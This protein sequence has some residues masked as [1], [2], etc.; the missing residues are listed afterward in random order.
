[1]P[2]NLNTYTEGKVNDFKD[3]NSSYL[4]LRDASENTNGKRTGT[5]RIEFFTHDGDG[6]VW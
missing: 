6:I 1:M 5:Q 4:K 3:G 2:T